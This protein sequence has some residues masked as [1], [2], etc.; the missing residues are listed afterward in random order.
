MAVALAVT[1]TGPER[2]SLDHAIG[3]DDEITGPAW[4][5][6][7]FAAAIVASL[8]TTTLGRARADLDEIPG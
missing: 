8:V 7:V 4:A 3:W 2:L 6:L 5:S 1:I